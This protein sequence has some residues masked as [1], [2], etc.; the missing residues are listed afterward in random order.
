MFHGKNVNNKTNK[1]HNMFLKIAYPDRMPGFWELLEERNDIYG[2]WTTYGIFG[3]N[4][5]FE[6]FLIFVE[7]SP[8]TMYE[9]FCSD[10]NAYHWL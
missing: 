5:K 8:I 4:R 1:R 2:W 9:R 10:K 7:T 6:D 3:K